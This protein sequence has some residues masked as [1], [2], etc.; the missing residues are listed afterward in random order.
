L[1]VLDDLSVLVVQAPMAGGPSTPELAAAVNRGGGLGFVAAGYLTPERLGERLQRTAALTDRPFGVNLFVGSGAP[2]DA[3]AVAAYGQ[4]LTGV[5]R[6]AG[7]ELGEPRFDD[8]WFTEKAALL[9]DQSVPGLSVV[10]FTFGLP[11]VSAARALRAAGFELWMTVTSVDEARAAAAAGADALIVQGIEAGGHRGVFADDDSQSELTLLAALQLIAAAV[12]LPLVGAGAIMTGAALAAVLAAGATA[13]QLGTAYLR[14]P[15]AG[16]SEAQRVATAGS[17]STVLTRAFSGRAARGIANRWHLD[18]G[19][20]A[21]HAYPEVHHL[22]SPLRAAGRA[23]GDPDLI[24]LWA[25]EAHALAASAP[26]EEITR[27]LGVDAAAA[28]A[29]AAAR[30][31]R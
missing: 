10:S 25:G 20:A 21:P 23:A 4:R 9:V 30:L 3:D 24:N 19:D 18:H 13:G 14:S 16:T 26:A 17:E 7:V 22:T 15:E 2:A 6:R 27:R 28:I 12:P 11:P 29:A 8:D 1:T 31:G 5:A